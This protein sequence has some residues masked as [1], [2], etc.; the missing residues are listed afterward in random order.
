MTIL[1][2]DATV[3]LDSINQLILGGVNMFESLLKSA[4]LQSGNARLI[5]LFTEKL[6]AEKISYTIKLDD[7]NHRGAVND[8]TVPSPHTAYK[9]MQTIYVAHADEEKALHLLE[10]AKRESEE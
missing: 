1:N 7:L 4:V 2:N 6:K 8:M 3:C 5:S 10:L 9:Q